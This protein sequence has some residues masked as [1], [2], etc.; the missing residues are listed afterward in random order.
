MNEVQNDE[1]RL[2]IAALLTK[3]LI[4]QSECYFFTTRRKYVL[5]SSCILVWYNL[6]H[7]QN[8]GEA[9]SEPV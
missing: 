9:Y 6:L 4:Y 2:E 8:K 3:L 1:D 5:Y 7:L